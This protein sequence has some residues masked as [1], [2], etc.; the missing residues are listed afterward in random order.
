MIMVEKIVVAP[1][2]VRGYGNIVDN[3]KDKSDLCFYNSFVNADTDLIDGIRIGI[4]RMIYQDPN[5]FFSFHQLEKYLYVNSDD[6]TLSFDSTNKCLVFDDTTESFSLGFDSENKVLYIGEIGEHDY[7]I[8]FSQSSYTAVGGSATLEIT[9][10][11]SNVP[12][13]GASV[14]VTGSDSSSYTGITNSNGI[15]NVTVSNVS[16]TV[17]FTGSYSN[18]SATCTVTAQSYL[19]YDA[20]DSSAGLSNYGSSE[21]VRGSTAVMSMSYDSSE[22]AYAVSGSGNWHAY[23]PIPALNDEDEYTISIEVKTQNNNFNNIGLFLD[24]RN[25]TT[26]YGLCF[27]MSSYSNEFY[28]RQYRLS[29]DGTSYITTV[30]LDPNTWYRIEYTVDGSSLTGKI[31]DMNDN[32]LATKNVTLSVSN[33]S[34]GIFMFC[35]SGTTNS[36]GWVRNIK[37]ESL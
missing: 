36:K 26:S 10:L 16:G 29:S 11:D 33:K 4:M 28:S 34:M 35:E 31:Y 14:T 5:L 6:M 15:A 22:N 30:S 17:T 1:N 7:S 8:A 18:V 21:C 32:L 37:A 2:E 23:T 20:C 24:N 9:L 3:D 25:D 19:F 27:S 13:Q 12:V